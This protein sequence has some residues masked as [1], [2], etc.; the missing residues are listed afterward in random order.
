MDVERA[1][2]SLAGK[3]RDCI[4]PVLDRIHHHPQPVAGVRWRIGSEHG[5]M[6][7]PSPCS[8]VDRAQKVPRPDARSDR[9]SPGRTPLIVA[10]IAG[11]SDDTVLLYG[12]LDKQPPMEGWSD[13][14]GPVD[15]VLRD[16][17]AL[18]SRRRR[19]RLRRV[20]IDRRDRRVAAP[21]RFRTRAAWYLIEACEESGSHDLPA[22]VDALASRIG[23]P[24]LDR[25]PR[26]RLRQLRAAVGDDLAARPRRRHADRHPP[27]RRSALGRRHRHRAVDLP[28]RPPAAEPLEDETSGCI[29]AAE[30]HAEVPV[31]RRRTDAAAAAVLGSG[32]YASFPFAGDAGRWT[33]DPAAS[34]AATAPGS[35]VSRSPA[36]TACPAIANAG[37]VLRPT[38]ALEALRS[39][40]SDRRRGTRHRGVEETSSRPTRP[41]ERRCRF[42]G[43][44]GADGWNAPAESPWL[45]AVSANEPPRLLRPAPATSAR[46]APS[47][48]WACSARASPQ[49]QF[50]ITGVLGPKSNAHGPNEFLDLA[51]AER[52]TGCVAQVLEDHFRRESRIGDRD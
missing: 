8:R 44:S 38:T 5:H 48:S 2:K 14:L 20:R 42:D 1:K 15:P 18:R 23:S 4:L 28:H 45:D 19:R 43:E 6:D 32:V 17:Q 11:S 27:G 25:L 34:A 13:G 51:T 3:W 37:N 40:A 52:L 24:E 26:L 31:Q 50:V 49:A 47:P 16:G 39:T 29:R 12:H 21:R 10:E 33:D 7:R 41:T 30:L 35:P 46:A 36:P 22:Y 9:S